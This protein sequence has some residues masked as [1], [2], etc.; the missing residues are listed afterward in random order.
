MIGQAAFLAMRTRFRASGEI[1]RELYA[2][3]HRL[4]AVIIFGGRLAPAYSPSG[5]WDSDAQAD[6]LHDWIEHRLL[7]TN[8][9][10][11]AFDLAEHP[12]PFLASLE[13]SFR[14]H[15]ENAKERGELD[16]LISRSAAML[17]DDET[18]QE[19][20]SGSRPSDSWWGLNGWQDPEP[21]QG[22]D[23]ALIAAAWALG[24]QALFRYSPSVDR[25]SPVLSSETLSTFLAGLF[26]EVQR[27]LTLGHLAQVF[28]AR[29]DLG[30]AGRV[31]LTAVHE[32]VA[33]AEEPL[34]EWVLDAT[35]SLLAE[36]SSRQT[37]AILRRFRGETL[38]EIAT[39]L[40]VSRGTADNALRTAG[41]L[42]D[43][44]CVDGITRELLL[45]KAL[46]ALSLVN[47]R[48]QDQEEDEVQ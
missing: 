3:L 16:N 26:D 22:A 24:P 29:F 40:G 33:Q 9:L 28:R 15:L 32:V 46:D 20:I 34:P 43:K 11:A 2:L 48:N 5:Q 13:R 21:Y 17:R 23:S 45:E 12:R 8:A 19:H 38:E 37:E 10:L 44:Y 36:L 39:A 47:E 31:D 35:T 18:F 4:T 14:H 41:P 27:L 6:A 1:D 30:T 7:R 25:A 42:I